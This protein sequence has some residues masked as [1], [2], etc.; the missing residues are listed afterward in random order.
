[1]KE[2]AWYQLDITSAE[3]CNSSRTYTECIQIQAGYN[4]QKERTAAFEDLPRLLFCFQVWTL[5]CLSGRYCSNTFTNTLPL[6]LRKPPMQM[7][8]HRTPYVLA[9]SRPWWT[10]PDQK[11]AKRKERKS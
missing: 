1:M 5:P 6:N 11:R 2:Y 4:Q 9:S 10:L 3:K 7:F 8:D